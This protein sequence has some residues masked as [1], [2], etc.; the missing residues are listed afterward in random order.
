MRYGASPIPDRE[1]DGGTAPAAAA[2]PKPSRAPLTPSKYVRRV[3]NGGTTAKPA[4]SPIARRL[5]MDR[6]TDEVEEG[7]QA[8]VLSRRSGAASP[9]AKSFRAARRA[10]GGGDDGLKA[11]PAEEEGGADQVASPGASSVAAAQRTGAERAAAPVHR[12]Q[13]PQL[14][15][16]E[17]GDSLQ[18]AAN[19]RGTAFSSYAR[20]TVQISTAT[21][22]SIETSATTT[23]GVDENAEPSQPPARKRMSD[24]FDDSAINMDGVNKL[25]LSVGR[26]RSRTSGADFPKDTPQ[27]KRSSIVLAKRLHLTDSPSD[28]GTSGS[29]ASTQT[30]SD[31]PFGSTFPDRAPLGERQPFS[32]SST[33]KDGDDLSW[34]EKHGKNSFF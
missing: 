6:E 4:A 1:E 21:T 9:V 15:D 14:P 3:S 12:I 29:S 25:S 28:S 19:S 11:K 24:R 22:T 26:R 31:S 2:G 16:R 32:P 18:A 7:A 13:V 20:D 8:R 34:V 33:N 10:S 17:D 30:S 27:T 5:S 23:S